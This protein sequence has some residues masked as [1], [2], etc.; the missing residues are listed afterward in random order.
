[1]EVDIFR[2]WKLADPKTFHTIQTVHW[3][4]LPYW[5]FIPVGI[6]FIGSIMLFWVHPVIIPVSEIG[7]AFSIQLLSHILTAV[8]WGPLQAKLSKDTSGNNSP[9]LEQILKTHWIR[10]ILI[11]AYGLMLL[12]MTIQSLA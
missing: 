5:I 11:N 9:Y 6:S 10:T 7:L 4:K 1:M 3:K 12:F 2:S 8:Y